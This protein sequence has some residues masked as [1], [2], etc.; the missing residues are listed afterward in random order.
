MPVRGDVSSKQPAARVTP[1]GQTVGFQDRTS[2]SSPGS[3][4]IGFRLTWSDS[5]ED[6]GLEIVWESSERAETVP[7]ADVVP[8]PPFEHAFSRGDFVMIRPPTD[9]EAWPRVQLEAIGPEEAVVVGEDGERRRI[10]VRQ[11]VPLTRGEAPK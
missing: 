2:P 7:G 8:V 1:P 4:P 3:A 6:G 9:G 11:L 10:N 5:L